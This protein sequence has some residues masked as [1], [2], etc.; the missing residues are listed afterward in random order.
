MTAP[1]PLHQVWLRGT[2]RVNAAHSVA[3][4]KVA[5]KSMLLAIPTWDVS[6]TELLECEAIKWHFMPVE[7]TLLGVVTFTMAE[8]VRAVFFDTRGTP[9]WQL[10]EVVEWRQV[11][12]CSFDGRFGCTRGHVGER[13]LQDT[14]GLLLDAIGFGRRREDM[15]TVHAPREVA[16]DRTVCWHGEARTHQRFVSLH[17]R[18]LKPSVETVNN[19]LA[20]PRV[21]SSDSSH[22]RNVMRG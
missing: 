22:T 19:I 9:D 11:R 14:W 10:I 2:A 3:A 13:C 12:V 15:C 5:T 16:P 17:R 21:E 7:T 4:R 18:S 6:K 1:V 20:M 8:P